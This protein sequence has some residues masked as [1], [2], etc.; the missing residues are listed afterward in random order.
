[1]RLIAAALLATSALAFA[2]APLRSEQAAANPAETAFATLAK[3]YIDGLA[4]L[5]PTY[6]TTLGN[7]AFDGELPDISAAGRT[8]AAAFDRA[9]LAELAK[10]D[11]SKLS[12]DSQVDAALLEN[13][14]KYD[15]W[16]LDTLQ[17]WAWDAQI[18]NDI[19]GGSLYGLAAR[20]FAPWG[21]RLK[22]ATSRMEKLPALLAETRKQ[23][24]PARV[25]LVFAQTVSRQNGGIV[26]IAE[27][28]LAPHKSELNAADQARFDKALA[29]LRVAVAEHQ[30]WLDEVLVPQAKGDFRLGPERYDQKMRFALLSTM[31]RAELKAKAEQSAKDIRV[32]MYGLARQVLKG[33]PGAPEL[34][35]APNAE[36]QQK[37]IE[38]AL[39]LSY[40]QRPPR[41]ELMDKAKATLAEATAFVREKQLMTVP[42]TPVKIITMP[43]FQQGFA[44]AY[45]DSPGALERNL[46]TFYAISPIPEEWSDDQA[47]SFLRE[48]NNYMIH[49]L[50]IHEAMPGHYL[51]IAHSNGNPSVLRAVL[52]SGSF[53]EGWA[54]YA[55]SLMADANYLNGDPLFKMT[56][57]KMRL[58]SVTNTLLDIGIQTEGMTRDQA[59]TLMTKGAFQ[60]EREASGK[61]TRANLSST[62]LLS[63]YVGYAEHIALREEARK[64]QGAS[65][66]L[67][68]YNDAVLSHGSP[69]A[70]YV[71][72]LMFGLPIE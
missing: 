49:D 68:T 47:T 42:D 59:M 31:T 36:Q 41:T 14:L 72:A 48:Y 27:S 40:A 9:L 24:V 32:E 23:L 63:Y 52:G 62:Q 46:D 56:V 65:F 69:P 54:V 45:C 58:R 2:T 33:R 4:K 6:A 8:Q 7:H 26:E 43:K 12:R 44:V 38:A 67:K 50:S 61:W 11:R 3:R 17:N 22:S 60:Q 66:D 30:K 29:G 13:A 19:A 28:M 5:S 39:E 20:D 51:Q 55:E 34:P 57:L 18:Y 64:R 10:I 37:A 70:K 1:M 35:D 16:Q 21:Q 15:L 25:P 71:R 53:V